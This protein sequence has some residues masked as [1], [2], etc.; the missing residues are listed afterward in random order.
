MD[1]RLSSE[2]S[3]LAPDRATRLPR[4]DRKRHGET[5]ATK[6]TLEQRDM[7]RETETNRR[8]HVSECRTS[9]RQSYYSS[10]QR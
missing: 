5:L 8:E 2:S 9:D 10:F 3:T 7:N 6:A 4:R 1:S